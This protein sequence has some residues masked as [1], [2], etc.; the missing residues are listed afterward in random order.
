MNDFI[1]KNETIQFVREEDFHLSGKD[2]KRYKFT[3]KSYKVYFSSITNKVILTAH[4]REVT[5]RPL[6]TYV[7]EFKDTLVDFADGKQKNYTIR[8]YVISEYLDNHVDTERGDFT[9]P[10]ADNDLF[11]GISV[12]RIEREASNI[13][14]MFFNEYIQEK[15][16]AK[17]QKVMDYVSSRAPWNKNLLK[18]L[19]MESLPLGISDLD[20]E[21]RFQKIKFEKEQKSRIE[22][23]IFWLRKKI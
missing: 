19:D 18:D 5:N 15:F 10:Q 14:K 17:K 9:L 1:I 4:R 13:T 7:P 22:I 6:H 16:Q 21:L 3:V 2:R 12:E 23:M 11:S 8:S 20:L